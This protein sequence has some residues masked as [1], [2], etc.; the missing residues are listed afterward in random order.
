MNSRPVY[1]SDADRSNQAGVIAKLERAFGLEG[2][3]WHQGGMTFDQ[4]FIN[5]PVALSHQYRSPLPGLYLCGAAS[6][7]GGGLSGWAGRNAAR[8]VLKDGVRHGA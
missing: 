1:E 2:G 7:P 5:R 4:F 8:E 3:H 6:H